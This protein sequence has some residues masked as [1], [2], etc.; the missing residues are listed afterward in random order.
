MIDKIEVSMIHDLKRTDT[1]TR[2]F[3]LPRGVIQIH[4]VY[5]EKAKVKSSQLFIVDL[6]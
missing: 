2:R 4:V 1:R 5:Y 6:H 3:I